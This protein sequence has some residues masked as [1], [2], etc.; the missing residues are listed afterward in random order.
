MCRMK[1]D[2]TTKNIKAWVSLTVRVRLRVR[3]YLGLVFGPFAATHCLGLP[4]SRGRGERGRRRQIKAV[5]SH[6][7]AVDSNKPHKHT[8]RDQILTVNSFFYPVYFQSQTFSYKYPQN[9][10]LIPDAVLWYK[11]VGH[12]NLGPSS[13]ITTF[14]THLSITSFSLSS[15]TI[16]I[17]PFIIETRTV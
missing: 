3:G 8:F 16:Q 14:Y 1:R 7:P 9:L 10:D 12:Q 5:C 17:K 4:S 6:H 15:R 13:Q 11:R 2:I